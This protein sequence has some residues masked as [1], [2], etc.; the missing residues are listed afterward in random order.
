MDKETDLLAYQNLPLDLDEL[1]IVTEAEAVMPGVYS[2]VLEKPETGIAVEGYI[3]LNNADEITETAKKY[4]RVSSDFPELLVFSEDE[5]GNSQY[6][7]GYEHFRYKILHHL[8]LPENENIRSI[9]AVGA[10]LYPD[11]FGGYP[12]PFLTPWGCTTRNKIIANG[13]YWLET[14][15]CRRGLAVAY[16]K[17]GDLSDGASTLAEPFDAGQ[18][19][20]NRKLPGYLFFKETDSCVPLFELVFWGCDIQLFCEIDRAALM[21]AIY[22]FHPEYAIQHNRNEQ[23]GLNDGVGLFLQIMGNDVERKSFPDRLISMSDQVGTEFIT[24]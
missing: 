12:V 20:S 15:Q 21:N 4:G 2:V 13:V 10:E 18:D 22:Q 5:T 11:Y 23:A 19:P 3:V 7:I 16:P 6:I 24:F 17:Y 9:A 14:E 8:P 1:G